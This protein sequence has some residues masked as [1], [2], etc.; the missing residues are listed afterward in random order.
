VLA[1][2]QRTHNWLHRA[3]ITAIQWFLGRRLLGLGVLGK[4]R[5]LSDCPGAV[6][7]RYFL[8]FGR[9]LLNFGHRLVGGDLLTQPIVRRLTELLAMAEDPSG[10]R[11]H[12]LQALG[13]PF[14]LTRI[15]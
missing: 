1:Y 7:A 12:G 6:R 8:N 2:A 15:Q 14:V 13:E 3:A 11:V 10:A 9:H 4:P 5:Q